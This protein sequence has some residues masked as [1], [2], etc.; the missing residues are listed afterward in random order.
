MIELSSLNFHFWGLRGLF[1]VLLCFVVPGSISAQTAPPITAP[2]KAK[3]SGLPIRADMTPEEVQKYFG[4]PDTKSLR[5][6]S[7][8]MSW[9]YGNSVI[10]FLD[11]RVSAWTNDGTLTERQ[12][13]AQFQPEA[14]VESDILYEG[15]WLNAWTPQEPISKKAILAELIQAVR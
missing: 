6:G 13:M 2:S 10:F 5:Q 9:Y 11:N 1:L 7:R 12:E 8:R 4:L 3:V 15:G 14:A